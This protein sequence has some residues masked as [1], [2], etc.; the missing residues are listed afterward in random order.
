MKQ[1][2]M[3]QKKYYVIRYIRWKLLG[4]MLAGEVFIKAGHGSKG[5]GIIKS[6]LLIKRVYKGLQGFLIPP[7]P[8]TYFKMQKYYQNEPTIIF[9]IFWDFLMFYQI[10]LSPQV[11]RCAIITY[12]HDI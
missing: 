2:K 8:L 5:K 7:H 6:W 3:K 10:F 9:I 12:E 4:N 1:F 11:K